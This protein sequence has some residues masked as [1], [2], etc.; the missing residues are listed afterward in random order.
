MSTKS[1]INIST[2]WD[3]VKV[4]IVPEAPGGDG[5]EYA[6]HYAIL[7]HQLIKKC[8]IYKVL[9]CEMCLELI[10]AQFLILSSCRKTLTKSKIYCKNFR[11]RQFTF[12]LNQLFGY[13]LTI[14]VWVSTNV[15]T[16]V[17]KGWSTLFIMIITGNWLT[18]AILN[19][20]ISNTRKLVWVCQNRS[21]IETNNNVHYEQEGELKQDNIPHPLRSIV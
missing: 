6:G 5:G 15:S 16:H 8:N 2:I 14:L 17:Y 7:P 9:Y 12:S 3:I 20:T 13:F 11:N 10:L 1:E 21:S 19:I 18:K 4:E